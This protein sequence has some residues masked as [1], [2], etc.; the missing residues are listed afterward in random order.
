MAKKSK[1]ADELGQLP[2]PLVLSF[3]A[4]EQIITDAES[5]NPTI[6]NVFHDVFA[7][8]YPS[9][10][11]RLSVFIELTNGHGQ[12]PLEIRLVHEKTQKT[13]F[14]M[15][16]QASFP[17][18]RLVASLSFSVANIILHSSGEYRLQLL[19]GSQTLLIERRITA[20]LLGKETTP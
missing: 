12:T 14:S 15:S 13:V 7:T 9:L 20:H 18:P 10:H 4:C 11:P 16:A 8:K 2:P 19:S 3:V 1:P 17:D 5:R 6:V